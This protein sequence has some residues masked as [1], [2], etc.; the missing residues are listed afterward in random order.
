MISSTPDQLD[1]ASLVAALRAGDEAAFAWLVRTYNGSLLRLASLHVS[2]DAVAEEVVQDTWLGVLRGIDRF[3]GRCSLKTWIFQILLNRARSRGVRE[4]RSTPVASLTDR[5]TDRRCEDL[6]DGTPPRLA[7]HWTSHPLSADGLPEERAEAHEALETLCRAIN[8]L[9]DRYREVLVLRD[10]EDLT[11]D[12]TCSRL[13][14]TKNNQRVRLHRARARV[15]QAVHPY[16][17]PAPV[18][19]A[20]SRP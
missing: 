2:S 17:D 7:G 1:D 18:I 9:P 16:F 12:E 15:R 4:H 11:S 14:L 20:V 6:L 10:L 19:P 13:N 3:E 8:D 5:G